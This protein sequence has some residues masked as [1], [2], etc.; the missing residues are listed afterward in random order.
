MYNGNCLQ[1]GDGGEDNVEVF[2]DSTA[3]FKPVVQLPERKNVNG[4]EEESVE[5]SGEE[6]MRFIPPW[7]RSQ[8]CPFQNP[9]ILLPLPPHAAD[10]T[11]YEF[12]PEGSQWKGRGKGGFRLNLDKSGQVSDP[13]RC[14]SSAPQ[15][16][17]SVRLR[18]V[19][20]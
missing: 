11:L 15:K 1:G 14:D 8:H 20:L 13:V 9:Y 17:N 4:E 7:A 18:S 19:T 16:C 12:D 10:G 6:G 2:A 5:F 3:E